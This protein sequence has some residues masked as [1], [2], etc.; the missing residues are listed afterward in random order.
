MIFLKNTIT[1]CFSSMKLM[2][3]GKQ[4]F[5]NYIPGHLITPVR[6]EKLKK[7]KSLRISSQN[8]SLKVKSHVIRPTGNKQ[9]IRLIID[10]YLIVDSRT[11]VLIWCKLYCYS[12]TLVSPFTTLHWFPVAINTVLIPFC[13]PSLA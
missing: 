2:L 1:H 12:S 13:D 5:L 6:M 3:F 4:P 7:S 9:N 11:G 10:Q 8:I